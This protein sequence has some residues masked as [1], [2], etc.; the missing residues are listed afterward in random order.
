MSTLET[1]IA[2]AD[3]FFGG[4]Y[5]EAGSEF[6]APVKSKAKWFVSK[7]DEP[8][9]AAAAQEPRLLD[10]SI[11]DIL[12]AAKKLSVNELNLLVAEE[13]AGKA[14]KGLLAKLQDEIA[15]R[16]LA[17]VEVENED[18]PFA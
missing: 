9:A 3:G 2:L 15:N 10:G 5:I 18:N 12:E 13:Q 14:R 17:P 4:R 6:T 1:K 7:D 11:P 8:E 16:P